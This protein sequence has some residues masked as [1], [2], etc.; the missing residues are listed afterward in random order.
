MKIANSIFRLKAEFLF[1][2]LRVFVLGLHS[3]L[4]NAQDC[5]NNIDFES[6][7]FQD[8]T[9]YVG[10]VIE[11]NN[12]NVIRLSPTTQPGFNR[13]TIV[14][15]SPANGLDPYGNF[16]INCPNGSGYSVKLGNELGGALAEGLVYEFTI[17]ANQDLFTLIYH[18]AV[19]FQEPPHLEHQQPRFEVEVIN[20]TRNQVFGC[21]SFAFRP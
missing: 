2:S 14:T 20:V 17:P 5:P 19:V 15:T 4:A 9:C 3:L 10:F 13:H 21:A 1:C 18:Y 11:Q 8:W 12:N 7:T 16:P 6:G